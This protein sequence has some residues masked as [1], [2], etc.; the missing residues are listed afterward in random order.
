MQ[1]FL[2]Y[3]SFYQ[4]ARVLDRQRLGKQRVETLQI[5]KSLSDPTYG[6]QKEDV[7]DEVVRDWLFND[8]EF[9][10]NLIEDEA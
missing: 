9:G 2:P 8:I 7:M 6:W 3:S 4:S 10:W 1:T 5:L